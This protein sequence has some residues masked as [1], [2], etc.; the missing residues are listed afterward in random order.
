[1][2]CAVQAVASLYLCVP[3]CVHTF[4]GKV[5]NSQVG[6]NGQP[7]MHTK[8]FFRSTNRSKNFRARYWEHRGWGKY[9]ILCNKGNRKKTENLIKS[10]RIL[11]TSQ[12]IT[13]KYLQKTGLR[14]ETTNSTVHQSQGLSKGTTFIKWYNFLPFLLLT[15]PS[16]TQRQYLHWG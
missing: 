12:E 3:R 13:I 14:T 9:N 2:S 5:T 4:I 16:M 7:C 15:N 1:M 11:L 8:N 6:R 10:E